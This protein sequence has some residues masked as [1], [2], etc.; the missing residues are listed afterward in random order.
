MTDYNYKS[1]TINEL[2]YAASQGAGPLV[3]S[4]ITNE[5][6]ERIAVARDSRPE[7]FCVHT[8]SET[9]DPFLSIYVEVCVLCSEQRDVE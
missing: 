9:Y 2:V 4:R 3:R 5:I 1:M 7:M 8:W 6:E